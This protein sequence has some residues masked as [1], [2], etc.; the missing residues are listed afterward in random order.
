MNPTTLPDDV[1]D[2]LATTANTVNFSIAYAKAVRMR[3]RDL[4]CK[5]AP[6]GPTHKLQDPTQ[7]LAQPDYWESG[8]PAQNTEAITG[9]SQ[10]S[11]PGH[12]AEV[13]FADNPPEGTLA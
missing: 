11:R 9:D 12:N 1:F 4:V 13:I 5:Y 8:L 2:F 7:R 10:T 3:A 6:L